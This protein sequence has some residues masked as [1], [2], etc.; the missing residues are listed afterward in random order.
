MHMTGDETPSAVR[1]GRQPN[2]QR[3]AATQERLLIAAVESLAELGYAGT[4]TTEVVKR[5]GLSRGALFLHFPTRQA[6]MA[7]A[8][9]RA[10]NELGEVYD[11]AFTTA[12]SSGEPPAVLAIEAI[13]HISQTPAMAVVN[14]LFAE[15]STSRTLREVLRPIAAKSFESFLD[16]ARVVLPNLD[17]DDATLQAVLVMWFS[18]LGMAA[19]KAVYLDP[20][21]EQSVLDGLTGY[22]RTMLNG[23]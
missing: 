1:R 10:I 23:G 14:I 20:R 5:S 2:P 12:T 8:A 16:R 13:H 4:T 9:D 7:A 22:A 11:A 17:G 21:A 15:A 6:L 18:L 3:K 19:H